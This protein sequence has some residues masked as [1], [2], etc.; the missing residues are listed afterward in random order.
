MREDGRW[1]MAEGRWKMDE[2]RGKRGGVSLQLNILF[3]C[4]FRHGCF[5]S[6]SGVFPRGR[7]SVPGGT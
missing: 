1:K 2:G 5:V 3:T 6:C 4:R 7:C